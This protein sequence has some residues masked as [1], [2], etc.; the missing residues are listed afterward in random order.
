MA[1]SAKSL[2]SVQRWVMSAL[3]V[4][5]ILHLAVGISIAAIFLD[6]PQLSAEIGLNVIAAAFGV[7]AIASG[8]AIHGRSMLTPWLLVG[9]VPGMLGLWLTLR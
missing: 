3:A 1:R 6:Q 4:T 7:V 8:F 9:T 2:T 5:T